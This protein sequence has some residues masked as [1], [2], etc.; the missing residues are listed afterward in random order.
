MLDNFT[1]H[2]YHDLSTFLEDDHGFDFELY[3]AA[4]ESDDSPI[5]QKYI[6]FLN[7]SSEKERIMNMAFEYQDIIRDV[8]QGDESEAEYNNRIHDYFK[9]RDFSKMD[10]IEL[11]NYF[12]I[13]QYIFKRMAEQITTN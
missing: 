9:N 3:K 4:V 12:L 1:K 5:T 13:Q 11:K 6:E 7:M 2:V 8:E 10:T